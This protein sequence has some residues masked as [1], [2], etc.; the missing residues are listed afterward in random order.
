[1]GRLNHCRE[2]NFSA[3]S[4]PRWSLPLEP[5][6]CRSSVNTTTHLLHLIKMAPADSARIQEAQ[7][8]AKMDPRKAEAQYKEIISKPPAATSDAAVREYET[9]LMNLGEL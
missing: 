2:L 7:K 8:M 9:A 4:R 1:M 3:K 5:S 6:I